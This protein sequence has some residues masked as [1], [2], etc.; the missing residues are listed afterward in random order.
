MSDKPSDK[1]KVFDDFYEV[2]CN[3]CECWWTNTCDGVPKGANRSCNS[4]KA[5]RSV[6]IPAKIERLESRLNSL[7]FGVLVL[8]IVVA[9]HVLFDI[10]KPGL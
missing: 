4:F 7:S 10:L 6:V 2:D 8:D 5:T 9:I 1:P 3:E